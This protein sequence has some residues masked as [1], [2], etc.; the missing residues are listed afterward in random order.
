VEIKTLDRQE[1][2]T[3]RTVPA[4][5]ELTGDFSAR[6]VTIRDPQTGQAFPGNIIPQN[7]ITPDGRA[8][9]NTY[10]AMIERAA[11]YTNTPTANNSTYQLDFPFDWHQELVRVDFRPSSNHGF[12]CATCTTTTT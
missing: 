9:A 12:Y 7:R 1:N 11:A 2:P 4:L 5:A 8:I 6:G 3:R 10:R